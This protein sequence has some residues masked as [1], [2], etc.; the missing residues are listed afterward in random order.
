MLDYIVMQIRK[1]N[2]DWSCKNPP[3]IFTKTVL[4]KAHHV[5]GYASAKTRQY[6]RVHPSGCI[7]IAVL[8]KVLKNIIYPY[9]LHVKVEVN[10]CKYSMF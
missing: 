6:P 1:V 7:C 5:T 2:C 9:T 10:Y 8:K 4:V 3:N